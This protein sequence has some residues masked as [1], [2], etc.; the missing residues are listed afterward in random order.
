M[1]QPDPRPS[2]FSAILPEGW[3]EWGQKVWP[4]IRQP[5]KVGLAAGLLTALYSLTLPNQYKSEARI[6]PADARAGGGVAAA[7]AAAVGVS[8]PGQESAD[9]AYVDILNS[10]R[11]REALLQTRFAFKVRTWYFGAE[12]SREQTLLEY[13]G[14][15]NMD[16]AITS[17]KP[18]ITITRDLK[19]KLLTIAVETESPQLSQQVAQR[20][21]KLLDEFVVG[22]SQTRGGAKAAFSEK[23]L[24]EARQEMARAE[25][26][27]RIFLDG[28]RNYVLSSDP[29]IRL[30]GISLDNEFKLRTQLVTT[31]SIARE[32]AL[33]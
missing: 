32:Q 8:I 23:R 11:L 27:F 20:Y 1:S 29:A 5:V 26:A 4:Q 16:R 10:R 33:L 15:K 19:T 18:M 28:N 25:E 7:A 12:Q 22:K 24:I 31:L 6:L 30:K 2:R 21:I 9:A 13:L 14:K 3:V 17:L